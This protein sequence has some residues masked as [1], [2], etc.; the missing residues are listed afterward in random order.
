MVYVPEE[1][2]EEFVSSFSELFSISASDSSMIMELD[3][4]FTYPSRDNVSPPPENDT[5]R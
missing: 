5:Q 4:L 3:S 1:P 2:S